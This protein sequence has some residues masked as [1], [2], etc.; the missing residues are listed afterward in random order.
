MDAIPFWPTI[1]RNWKL[2]LTV[3]GIVG[4]AT[5]VC[6]KLFIPKEYASSATIYA[7]STY[8]V[9]K[10]VP[11]QKFGGD[12]ETQSL[13]QTLKSKIVQDSIIKKYDLVSH[14]EID[15]NKKEWKT[16]LAKEYDG[17]I[18]IGT[19]QY[20]AI[21]ITVQDTDPEL[22]AK[23]A[24]DIVLIGGT[25]KE[26]ILK[27]NVGAIVQDWKAEYTEK[28]KEISE[29]QASLHDAGSKS[30]KGD[31]LSMENLEAEKLRKQFVR[32]I[33]KLGYLKDVYEKSK[34]F[35]EAN[36]PAYYLISKAEPNYKKV[37]PKG[38]IFGLL[39]SFAAAALL[40]VLLAIKEQLAK[41][42]EEQ[43]TISSDELVG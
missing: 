31:Y 10:I 23:I 4:I 30:T 15:T 40:T 39:A 37:Y 5:I 12:E 20:D 17:R 8:D 34:T 18:D 3:S 33:N 11:D 35:H 26:K 25:T 22:A 1:S 21:D 7:A 2:L 41:K 6:V 13:I 42:E 14:Y 38:S 32:E 36:T 28:Q 9:N 27:D 16:K 24:N 29:L 43:I 19:N